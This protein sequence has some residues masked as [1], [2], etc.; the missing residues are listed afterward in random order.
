MDVTQLQEL[1]KTIN[2]TFDGKFNSET[3]AEVV[4]T[5]APY[6]TWYLAKGFLLSVIGMILGTVCVFWIA[7]AIISYGEKNA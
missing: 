3:V 2:L 7:K 5:I 1:A 6:Y 4:K